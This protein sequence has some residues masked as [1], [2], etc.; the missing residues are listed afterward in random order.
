MDSR[1][2]DIWRS[3]AVFSMALI[4]A[5]DKILTILENIKLVVNRINLWE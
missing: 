3:C 5:R 2:L 4:Y 1:K